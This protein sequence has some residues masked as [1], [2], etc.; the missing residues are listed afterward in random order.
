MVVRSGVS[1]CGCLGGVAWL[2]LA[3]D[4]VKVE[5]GMEMETGC[6]GAAVSRQ[7]C[8][9]SSFMACVFVWKKQ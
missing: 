7:E 6:S 9:S 8:Y 5:M 2:G 1:G 3:R 4:S